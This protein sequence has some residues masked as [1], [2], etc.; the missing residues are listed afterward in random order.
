MLRPDV[1]LTYVRAQPFRP[2]RITMTSGTT[3][4]VRHPEM[5]RVGKDFFN[6]Y[7]AT[8][9]EAPADRWE[10]VSLVLI[11]NV[12][13]LDQPSPASPGGPQGG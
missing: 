5:I 12:R 3:Y 8:P 9:P 6:Y 13:A 11:E 2:F 7:H 4:E 1:L 10:T